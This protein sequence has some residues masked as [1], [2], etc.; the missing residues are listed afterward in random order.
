MDVCHGNNTL[1]FGVHAPKLVVMEV[2]RQRAEMSVFSVVG[3]HAV[4][5]T[6]PLSGRFVFV[7]QPVRFTPF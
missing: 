1:T 3:E 4:S 7:Q 2:R 5:T 6:T